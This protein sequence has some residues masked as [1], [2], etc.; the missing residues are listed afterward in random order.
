M[1][2]TT[3]DSGDLVIP[4]LFPQ[5][6]EKPQIQ[7]L[8]KATIP[9]LRTK[10][11]TPEVGIIS[12]NIAEKV[13]CIGE[14]DAS[15][16]ECKKLPLKT[17]ICQKIADERLA[18][19]MQEPPQKTLFQ[20]LLPSIKFG[21]VGGALLAA[22]GV[23]MY[24]RERSRALFEVAVEFG[25]ENKVLTQVNKDNEE[26]IKQMKETDETNQQTIQGFLGKAPTN[27]EE[28]I[29]AH[30][31][32]E[33][34]RAV[35]DKFDFIKNIAQKT[36]NLQTI[37]S[38]EKAGYC[39]GFIVK[40]DALVTAKHCIADDDQISYGYNFDMVFNKVSRVSNDQGIMVGHFLPPDR[41]EKKVVKT[42]T[43]IDPTRDAAMIVFSIPVF[44]QQGTLNVTDKKPEI[45]D[46][47]VYNKIV[48]SF[49]VVPHIGAIEHFFTTN[50]HMAAVPFKVEHGNS[51]SPVIDKS[52]TVIGIVTAIDSENSAHSSFTTITNDRIEELYEEAKAKL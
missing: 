35:V 8:D 14:V 45:G 36:V 5:E 41:V 10:E 15:K 22:A 30:K 1:Q 12:S 42:S 16:P 44:A 2:F 18:K 40:N 49:S 50:T 48:T 13:S 47:A 27:D 4:D 37:T 19:T 51:G 28:L 43:V 52:G 32:R 39:Q 17:N 23:T 20:K 34:V 38:R 46:I 9:D 24:E 21:A 11:C 31:K 25:K 29:A 26:T 3:C 33:E 7:C 6:P